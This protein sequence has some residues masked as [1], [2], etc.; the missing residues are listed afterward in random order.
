ME[1]LLSIFIGVLAAMLVRDLLR[2]LLY[3]LT[4]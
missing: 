2:Y 4:A 3:M 1:L